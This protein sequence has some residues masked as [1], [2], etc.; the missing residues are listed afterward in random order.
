MVCTRVGFFFFFAECKLTKF[1]TR[2]IHV[3]SSYCTCSKLKM[4]VWQRVIWI[5]LHF[6]G[7][8]SVAHGQMSPVV[9]GIVLVRLLWD[10]RNTLGLLLLNDSVLMFWKQL[11]ICSWRWQK[12][13]SWLTSGKSGWWS[14]VL[15]LISFKVVIKENEVLSLGII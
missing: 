4:F 5:F 7:R 11:S 13:K 9:S 12:K 10:L 1:S 3:I 14:A 6:K 2:F 15:P 8:V